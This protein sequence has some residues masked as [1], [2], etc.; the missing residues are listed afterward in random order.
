[1]SEISNT[2]R[3]PGESRLLFHVLHWNVIHRESSRSRWTWGVPIN[4]FPSHQSLS[5]CLHCRIHFAPQCL[6]IKC[7]HRGTYCKNTGEIKDHPPAKNILQAIYTACAAGL[8]SACLWN[9]ELRARDKPCWT[10]SPWHFV[11]LCPLHKIPSLQVAARQFLS[12]RIFLHSGYGSQ[13]SLDLYPTGGNVFHCFLH[14]C[15]CSWLEQAAV[16]GVILGPLPIAVSD[17]NTFLDVWLLALLPNR[18]RR[19]PSCTTLWFV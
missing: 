16:P 14:C 19:S 8:E 17:V 1:M 5:E 9:R 15:S 18:S 3:F 4:V 6:Q 2:I 11:L 12:Q 10:Y 7:L 13:A